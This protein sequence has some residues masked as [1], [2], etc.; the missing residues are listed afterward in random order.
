MTDGHLDLPYL[1][2]NPS[3]PL[4]PSPLPL[5]ASDAPGEPINLTLYGADGRA[6]SARL[7]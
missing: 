1:V 3:S 7:P 2:G 4:P 5:W 6:A